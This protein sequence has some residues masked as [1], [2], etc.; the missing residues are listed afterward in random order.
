[1]L[2]SEGSEEPAEEGK[3]GVEHGASQVFEAVRKRNVEEGILSDLGYE[4]GYVAFR[5]CP[6]YGRV[7]GEIVYT[8]NDALQRMEGR[9]PFYVASGQEAL[10]FR[11]CGR[12][13]KDMGALRAELEGVVTFC[14]GEVGVA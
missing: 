8:F 11:Y 3:E 10:V 6:F 4:R 1:M 13:R 7:V 5:P 14:R 9:L 2:E 12:L